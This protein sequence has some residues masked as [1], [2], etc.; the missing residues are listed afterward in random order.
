MEPLYITTDDV[1]EDAL[2][3]VVEEYRSQALAEG[4]SPNTADEVVQGR[5]M[6]YYEKVCL[7]EQP[8]VKDESVQVNELLTEAIGALRENIVVRRFIRYELGEEN[9]ES[10]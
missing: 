6:K 2:G 1:P 3:P 9:K 5:L 10:E 7:L 8:F 4:V